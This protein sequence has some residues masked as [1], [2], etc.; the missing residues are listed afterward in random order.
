MAPSQQRILAFEA[1]FVSKSEQLVAEAY[2]L[3]QKRGLGHRH[4]IVFCRYIISKRAVSLAKTGERIGFRSFQLAYCVSFQ[5]RFSQTVILGSGTD[6][7][8]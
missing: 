3:T 5:L 8:D 7:T 2:G 1:L 6:L 4:V